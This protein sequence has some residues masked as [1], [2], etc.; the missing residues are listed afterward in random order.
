MA[1]RKT[2]GPTRNFLVRVVEDVVLA[3]WADK[4]AISR[5]LYNFVSRSDPNL[6]L[7]RKSTRFPLD[8]TPRTTL[9]AEGVCA[10][11]MR[12]NQRELTHLFSIIPDLPHSTYISGDVLIKLGIQVDTIN[13]VLW[14]LTSAQDN[15]NCIDP[16]KAKS[17]PTIPEV[18]QVANEHPVMLPP[19]TTTCLCACIYNLVNA[20]TIPGRSSNLRLSSLTSV[21]L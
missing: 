20:L 16:D 9:T 17:G 18:C 15:A 13:N 7:V 10:L 14:S 21:S 4:S 12:W 19:S 1:P 6:H 5:R 8:S 11:R 2:S 3:I